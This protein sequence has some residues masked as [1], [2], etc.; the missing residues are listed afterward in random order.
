MNTTKNII[1]ASDLGPGSIVW[2]FIYM[3]PPAPVPGIER[4]SSRTGE[5]LIY[6]WD[7]GTRSYRFPLKFAYLRIYI[8]WMGFGTFNQD[9]SRSDVGL[10]TCM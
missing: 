2:C 4:T 9:Y 8:A 5:A 3:V 10:Y 7:I 6:I 1:S